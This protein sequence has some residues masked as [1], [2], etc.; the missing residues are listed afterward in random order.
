MTSFERNPKRNETESFGSVTS[1]PPRSPV[2][3]G[4]RPPKR[5]G[6][7]RSTAWR[8]RKGPSFRSFAR[9][10]CEVAACCSA[11]LLRLFELKEVNA[12]ARVAGDQFVIADKGTAIG[13][14]IASERGEQHSAFQVPHLQRVVLRRGDRPPPV[15]RHRHAI[16]MTR[17][18]FQGAQCAA[19][20]PGPTPSASCPQTRRPPAARPASPPRH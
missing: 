12:P 2:T 3:H 14:A 13:R 4:R 17:V 5:T 20:C 11:S 9:N 18:A 7:P 19:A 16:D 1:L 6:G 8:C 10:Q 15:R